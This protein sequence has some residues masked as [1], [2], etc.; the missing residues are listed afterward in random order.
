MRDLTDNMP[1]DDVQL[2]PLCDQP[3]FD[4]DEAEVVSAH[5]VRFLVHT[6]C[7]DDAQE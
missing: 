4:Y 1:I 7:A 5:G 2:C 3:I 6:D